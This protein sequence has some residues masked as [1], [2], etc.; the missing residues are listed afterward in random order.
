MII[1]TSYK[2]FH[3]GLVRRGLDAIHTANSITPEM[4]S[5]DLKRFILFSYQSKESYLSVLDRE[6]AI[7]SA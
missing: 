1:V 7:S 5:D 4:A 6:K 3:L 2:L